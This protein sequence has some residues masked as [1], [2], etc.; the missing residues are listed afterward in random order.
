MLDFYILFQSFWTVFIT[1]KLGCNFKCQLHCIVV[2]RF[3]N[4]KR[5]I[6]LSSLIL[7]KLAFRQEKS[8]KHSYNNSSWALP[9][10]KY[11]LPKFFPS[12]FFINFLVSNLK[13]TFDFTLKNFI[14][15]LLNCKYIFNIFK[16][17]FLVLCI[18]N[19]IFTNVTNLYNIFLI[20]SD[21]LNFCYFAVF[22]SVKVAIK[23]F[24]TSIFYITKLV[25][26]LSDITAPT[27]ELF[28]IRLTPISN[29]SDC[30][31]R[32]A[33]FVFNFI[34]L[35]LLLPHK[36]DL[37][38]KACI[39]TIFIFFSICHFS[40]KK[41]LS[42][43]PENTLKNITTSEFFTY[44]SIKACSFTNMVCF[45]RE[46]NLLCF[47]KLSYRNNRL[48]S[49]CYY[50]FLLISVLTQDLLIVLSSI[51]MISGLFLKREFFILC[52]LT[53]TVFYQK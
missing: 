8:R 5:L 34:L 24:K 19:T 45:N 31:N 17:E 29:S 36:R 37:R 27:K 38:L 23:N 35:F 33:L 41:S 18:V 39:S 10:N 1:Q 16:K 12:P 43:F 20:F 32:I 44:E 14:N 3:L 42:S 50:Y 7:L 22:G 30:E 40:S 28:Q 46:L 15:A 26:Y 51:I 13:M 21:Y 53:S 47:S 2:C 9:V 52:I 49:N 6:N 4:L 11:N 48:I 25:I